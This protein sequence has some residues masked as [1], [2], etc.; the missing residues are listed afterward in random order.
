MESFRDNHAEQRFELAHE[1][2][3]SFCA[4]RRAED[5]VLLTHVETPFDL[6]GRG[7]A[8]QL[9]DAIVNHARANGL[10]LQPLCAYAVAYLARRRDVADVMAR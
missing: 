6:R 10:K 2:G 7:Y 1:G 3:V 8:V 5:D 9:M 4:Y